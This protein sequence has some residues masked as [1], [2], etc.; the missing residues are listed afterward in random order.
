MQTQRVYGT[1]VSEPGT[2]A[3]L[4]NWRAPTLNDVGASDADLSEV[5]RAGAAWTLTPNL[6]S[7]SSPT[8]RCLLSN[9]ALAAARTSACPHVCTTS[10]LLFRCYV[11]QSCWHKASPSLVPPQRTA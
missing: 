5:V 10:A 11:S 7:S 9:K 2:A 3:S 1:G 8:D 6:V 4:A